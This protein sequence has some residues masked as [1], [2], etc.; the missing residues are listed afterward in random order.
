M[1]TLEA[2][3]CHA[4]ILFNKEKREQAMVMCKQ[5]YLLDKCKQAQNTLKMACCDKCLIT[6]RKNEAKRL[7]VGIT[8]NSDLIE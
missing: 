5:C 1:Q 3:A 6:F 2:V 8:G 7:H 4:T